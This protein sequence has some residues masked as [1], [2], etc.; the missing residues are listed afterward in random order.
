MP[1]FGTS[2]TRPNILEL[3]DG[4]FK[5]LGKVQK[6]LFYETLVNAEDEMSPTPVYHMACVELALKGVL[7]TC[8]GSKGQT[9]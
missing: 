5:M 2:L 8:L 6:E 4:L 3:G 7:C 9:T 1:L